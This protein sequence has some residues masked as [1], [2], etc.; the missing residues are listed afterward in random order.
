M[1]TP[2]TTAPVARWYDFAVV[3]LIIA[4]IAIR[5]PVMFD[6]AGRAW[7]A[8]IL[9]VVGASA[10]LCV[11]RRPWMTVVVVAATLFAYLA[12]GFPGG[13][14]LLP[15]PIAAIALGLLAP[16]TVALCGAVA[17]SVAVVAGQ[18][19]GSGLPGTIA[20]AGPAWAFAF[21][22]GGNLLAQRNERRAA[23]HE[24]TT[25]LE[26][27]RVTE[28][29]LAIAR[30]LHDSVAH[31]LVTINVQSGVAA[32]L[33]DRKPAQAAVALDAIRQASAEVLDE[34]SAILAAL[35]EPG[36]GVNLTPAQRLSD[37]DSLI[38]RFRADGLDVA[39]RIDGDPPAALPAI[40]SASYRVVQEGLSNVVRHGGER[41]RV[42]VRIVVAGPRT[43]TVSVVDDGGRSPRPAALGTGLGLIGMRE[44]VSATGGTL[45]AGPH[46]G[47]FRVVAQWNPD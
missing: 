29:R 25:M 45:D 3:A 39:V 34:M 23:A 17:L 46:D 33:V 5:T 21:T 41:V 13:P 14:A 16:R 4:P 2:S 10:L 20:I 8:T 7:A 11:R 43:V 37:V 12:V 38:D 36:E 47:G 31:A 6:D 18:W 9:G 22:L 26:R 24:R 19:I 32:A 28:Q 44:R 1:S 35:R 30:D 40:S 15:G 42:S 27:Q